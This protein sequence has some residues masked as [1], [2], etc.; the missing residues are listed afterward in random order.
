[1][2]IKSCVIG[3]LLLCLLMLSGCTSAP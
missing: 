3:S 1:M 2:K